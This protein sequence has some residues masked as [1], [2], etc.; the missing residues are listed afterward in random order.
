M[1]SGL[2]AFSYG[3]PENATST[4]TTSLISIQS[5]FSV[6]TLGLGFCGLGWSRSDWGPGKMRSTGWKLLSFRNTLISFLSTKNNQTQTVWRR[7]LIGYGINSF[8]KAFTVWGCALLNYGY[9]WF[10]IPVTWLCRR[11]AGALWN[12]CE[13]PSYCMWHSAPSK[14]LFMI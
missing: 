2:F 13:R 3:P 6:H 12:V 14:A 4:I 10:L 8:Q 7:Q 9:C 11:G 1:D 5:F